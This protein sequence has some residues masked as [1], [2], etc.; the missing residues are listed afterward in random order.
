MTCS[1]DRHNDYSESSILE[2]RGLK[3]LQH[4]APPSSGT[5]VKLRVRVDS[6]LYKQLPFMRVPVLIVSFTFWD[7][8]LP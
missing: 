1:N 5:E 2:Q 4:Q 6:R 3:G 8:A 7:L